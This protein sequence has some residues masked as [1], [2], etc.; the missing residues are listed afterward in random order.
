MDTSG[1]YGG[2]S[3]VDEIIQKFGG[4]RALARAVGVSHGAVTKWKNKGYI[5]K[6]WEPIILKRAEE[7]GIEL[8]YLDFEYNPEKDNGRAANP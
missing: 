8:T 3:Y 2:M 1:I 4:L 5:Q 6:N 7:Q